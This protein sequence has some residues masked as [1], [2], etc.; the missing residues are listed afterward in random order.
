MNRLLHGKMNRTQFFPFTVLLV[1]LLFFGAV[2][3]NVDY[4]MI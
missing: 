1:S 4:L 3:Y 2:I